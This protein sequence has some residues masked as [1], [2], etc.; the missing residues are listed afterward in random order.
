[1][2]VIIYPVIA[3]VGL[4]FAALSLVGLQSDNTNAQ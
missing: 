4:V 2:S 3:V 1:M